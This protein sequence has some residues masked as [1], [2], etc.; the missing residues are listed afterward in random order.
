MLAILIGPATLTADN[1]NAETTYRDLFPHEPRTPQDAS[2][3]A[4][5][6]LAYARPL[7]GDKHLKLLLL[8]KSYEFGIRNPAGYSTA[9]EAARLLPTVDA[10]RAEESESKLVA[11]SRLAYQNAKGMEKS[12]AASALIEQ[13][14]AQGDRQFDGWKL[15]DAS[16][17]YADAEKIAATV[18][19]AARDAVHARQQQVEKVGRKVESL[20]ERVRKER[21]EDAARQLTLLYLL[22]LNKPADAAKYAAL[23]DDIALKKYTTLLNG[24]PNEIGEA[25]A[26]ELAQWFGRMAETTDA[27]AIS[28]RLRRTQARNFYQR[29]LALHITDDADRLKAKVAMDKLHDTKDDSD[30]F[31]PPTRI[32]TIDFE[33]DI[34]LGERAERVNGT[35]VLKGASSF[36]T[37]ASFP[38]PFRA[39]YDIQT[40]GGDLRLWFGEAAAEGMVIFNWGDKPDELRFHDP[41]TKQ[42]RGIAGRGRLVSK[43]WIKVSWIIEPTRCRILVSDREVWSTSG[44]YSTLVRPLGMSVETLPADRGKR[45]SVVTLRSL[46]IA[47]TKD[48]GN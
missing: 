24:P 45:D 5:K 19:P 33:H 20:K 7:T 23:S 21:G 6:L 40:N 26:L 18:A 41:A 42:P 1:T 27:T 4:G 34:T 39:D 13:L 15:T 44:N 35:I 46:T 48:A 10:E 11:V 2:A 36:T 17:S 9:T 25:D 22:D 30:F 32:E 14:V 37:R 8:E 29:Y 28:R 16:K 31:A 12:Q 3:F 43:D 38:V 47:T